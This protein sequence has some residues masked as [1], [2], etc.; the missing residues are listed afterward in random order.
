M[1]MPSDILNADCLLRWFHCDNLVGNGGSVYGDG[2]LVKA[3]HSLD[4]FHDFINGLLNII[5]SLSVTI[6]H[7]NLEAWMLETA[8]DF[9]SLLGVDGEI[10]CTRQQHDISLGQLGILLVSR[11][12]PQVAEMGDGHIGQVDK[13]DVRESPVG[14]VVM[15]VGHRQLTQREV[16]LLARGLDKVCGIVVTM[17]MRSAHSVGLDASWQQCPRHASVLIGVKDNCRAIGFY[18]EATVAVI[19][20]DSF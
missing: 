1:Q 18:F 2:R 14:S 6:M 12:T 16:E 9:G 8:D 17:L 7:E 20:D 10:P 3:V 5:A 11:Q 19:G 15:V 13:R 4:V